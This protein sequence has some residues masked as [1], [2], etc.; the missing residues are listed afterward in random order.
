[1]ILICKA[2][3]IVMNLGLFIASVM[4]L[5]N[6][7]KEETTGRLECYIILVYLV[8]SVLNTACLLFN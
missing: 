6:I 7:N 5:K 8:Y 1:M 4:A 2:F 3:L